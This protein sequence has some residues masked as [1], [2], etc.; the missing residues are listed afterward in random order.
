MPLIDFNQEQVVMHNVNKGGRLLS[1]ILVR[2]DQM[3]RCAVSTLFPFCY[4]VLFSRH[5]RHLNDVL[6]SHCV[7]EINSVFRCFD[8]I[9]ELGL[10]R[11]FWLS[12]EIKDLGPANSTS[13]LKS[14]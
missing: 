11:T 13:A 1:A 8:G 3:V 10:A 9:F 2:I 5:P 6:D 12:R 7:E 4:N 14:F